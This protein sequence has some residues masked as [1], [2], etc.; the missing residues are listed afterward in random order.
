MSTRRVLLAVGLGR[1]WVTG[2]V[3][4]V[5]DVST[6][7]AGECGFNV[8]GTALRS[9]ATD[10]MRPSVPTSVTGADEAA[11]AGIVCLTLES[12][13][14]RRDKRCLNPTFEERAE[15][16]NLEPLVSCGPG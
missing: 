16:A 3:S 5:G 2:T 9:G 11:E 12:L 10:W 14:K 6:E 1:T 8:K 4:M 7:S 13:L 15:G